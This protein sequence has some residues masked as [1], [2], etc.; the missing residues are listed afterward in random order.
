MMKGTE[1]NVLIKPSSHYV[2]LHG[3]EKYILTPEKTQRNLPTRELASFM[4]IPTKHEKKSSLSLIHFL[5]VSH[6]MQ[7][8][9][10]LLAKRRRESCMLPWQ[11]LPVHYL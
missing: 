1:Y 9:L 2:F 3:L 11:Q 5:S 10:H 4:K 6:S 8:F 7:L